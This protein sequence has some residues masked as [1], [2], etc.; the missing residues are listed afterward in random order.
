[1]APEDN[2]DARLATTSSV[3]GVVVLV[4][5]STPNPSVPSPPVASTPVLQHVNAPRGAELG[6]R[7]ALGKLAA[8]VRGS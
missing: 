1:M 5:C 8:H 3:A 4:R 7:M 2:V 6:T